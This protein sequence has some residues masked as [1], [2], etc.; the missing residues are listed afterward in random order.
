MSS[1]DQIRFGVDFEFH[2]LDGR[3]MTVELIADDQQI[4]LHPESAGL[5]HARINVQ[6]PGQVIM[7]FDGKNNATDTKVDGDGR[8]LADLCVKIKT[9]WLDQISL[10]S[11]LDHFLLLQTASGS[12]IPSHYIG[13]NGQ[14]T[15]D[16]PAPDAFGQ[17]MLW[18]R[19]ILGRS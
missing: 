19:L 9:I 8:I 11:N 17:I 18:N 16:L 13:F 7:R 10:S 2:Q 1:F 12:R 4:H 5:Y 15:L 14:I 6:L 3:M